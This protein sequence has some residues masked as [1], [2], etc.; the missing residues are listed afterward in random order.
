MEFEDASPRVALPVG[1]IALLPLAWYGISDS[2][3][4]GIVSAVNV[5]LIL[6][7][8]Y[9]AFSPVESAHEHGHDRDHDSNGTTP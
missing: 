1:L 5:V 6:A 7:C 9:I 4:A 3:M 2:V 8:L